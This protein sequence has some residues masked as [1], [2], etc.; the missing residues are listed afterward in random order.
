MLILLMI[1]SIYSSRSKSFIAIG[2]DPTVYNVE[3]MKA[4][5][6]KEMTQMVAEVHDIKLSLHRNDSKFDGIEIQTDEKSRGVAY[7]MFSNM[8]ITE[9]NKIVLRF[10]SL[11]NCEI[12]EIDLST[13]K[14]LNINFNS[15]AKTVFTTIKLKKTDG[16]DENIIMN[17]LKD[18]CKIYGN[19][20]IKSFTSYENEVKNYWKSKKDLQN[21][22]DNSNKSENN[23]EKDKEELKTIAKQKQEFENNI[24]NNQDQIKKTDE[25]IEEI[26]K[27]LKDGY[28][29]SHKNKVNMNKDDKD[30]NTIKEDLD[31][32]MKEKKEHEEQISQL[33]A[34]NRALRQHSDELDK[35]IKSLDDSLAT[36]RSELQRREVDCNQQKSKMLEIQ[37]KLNSNLERIA[38]VMKEINGNKEAL[39]KINTENLPEQMKKT[40][41]AIH[42]L[43][44]QMKAVTEVI[45][46]LEDEIKIA[47]RKKEDSINKMKELLSQKKNVAAVDNEKMLTKIDD[48]K[49]IYDAIIKTFPCLPDIYMNNMFTFAQRNEYEAYNYLHAIKPSLYSLYSYTWSY[50]N[51]KKTSKMIKRL[52]KLKIY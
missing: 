1:T 50:N 39:D 31:K 48:I 42:D 15:N 14:L 22:S 6:N 10:G 49:K 26:K 46:K 36:N 28:L 29:D 37:N 40:N 23:I 9:G 44:N 34:N 25:R 41:N 8:G 35:K 38:N 47:E 52:K 13:H 17:A 45:Q 5:Q 3:I 12:N 19:E 11:L 2:P 7:N 43:G 4:Y 20:I 18:Q 51:P 24:K 27:K 32:V 16:V 30:S 21:T 33:N